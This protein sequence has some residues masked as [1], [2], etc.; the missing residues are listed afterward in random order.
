MEDILEKVWN[1]LNEMDFKSQRNVEKAYKMIILTVAVISF[2]VAFVCGKFSYCIY[3]VLGAA[4]FSALLFVPAW[5][6]W[7]KNAVQWHKFK[8]L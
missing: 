7:K 8:P 3:G 1:Y 4:A 5:P 6:M 2:I